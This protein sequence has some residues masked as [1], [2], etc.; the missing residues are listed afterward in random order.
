MAKE[1]GGKSPAATRSGLVTGWEIGD[2]EREVAVGT[3]KIA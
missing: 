2:L 1:P 3:E